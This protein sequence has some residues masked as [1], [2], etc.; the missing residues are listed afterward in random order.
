MKRILG[1]DLGSNS[2]GWGL[3]EQ[4]FQQK[5]GKIIA[6]GSRIIPMD[7]GLLGDF[8]KGNSVSQTAERTFYRSTRKL[9]QRHLLRRERLH[10]VLH[11][12]G[13][14]PPHYDKQIDFSKRYGKFLDNTEPKIAYNEGKFLF[15]DSFQ[16][17][18]SDFKSH[19]PTINKIM[20]GTKMGKHKKAPKAL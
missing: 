9:R 6:S 5:E 11:I 16:E 15:M 13:F 1:L 7:Q 14:L 3:I 17:M 10:R 4:D 2:I 12:L 19:Q 8:E 18:L 20:G